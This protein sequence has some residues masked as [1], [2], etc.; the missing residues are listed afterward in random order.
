MALLQALMSMIGTSVG[1]VLNAIFG[2]AVVAL[3]G[4]PSQKQQTM[5]SGL[6]AMAAAWPL[7]LIGI[8]FPRVAAFLIAFV[9]LSQD[10][11]SWLMRALW[12]GLAVV[13]PLVVGAVVAAKAPPGVPREPFPKR[14]LRGFPLT[15]GIATAFFL[16]F[17]TVPVLRIAS[18][19]KRRKDEHVPCI[20]K[21]E[22]YQT[23]AA[24]I[25]W[26]LERYGLG[27][28][29]SKPSWW[30]SGPSKVLGK[31]GGKALRGLLPKDLA[32]WNGPELEL[33]LFLSDILVRGRNERT[34][35]VH[36]VLA[37][38]LVHSPALQTSDP[39][40]QQL[41]LKIR[42]IWSVL[43]RNPA[44]HAG[45]RPLWS[46]LEEVSKELGKLSVDYD[47]WQV[48]YRETLQLGRA[49]RGE[50][51]LLESL[52]APKAAVPKYERTQELSATQEQIT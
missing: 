35:F 3:F 11:P 48:L 26:I 12:L 19:L 22:G 32:Y 34:A 49:L 4:R 5:L 47:D 16:M 23:V 9:P 20:T 2:W 51:Q 15:L 36:G 24:Q 43:D 50:P 30:L 46:R 31:L 28:R 14:L 7:L 8:A 38:A 18:A 6:V 52:A 27:A 29:R 45:S 21:G 17:L 42:R 44:A 1:K 41:E 25:D 39:R 13:V 33:A 10:V 40:A 37:E